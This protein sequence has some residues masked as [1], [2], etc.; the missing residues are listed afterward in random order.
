[1]ASGPLKPPVSIPMDL[2]CL[3]RALVLLLFP[4]GRSR[5]RA[6]GDTTVTRWHW[7]G[8][9]WGKAW[10]AG[11]DPALGWG[12]PARTQPPPRSLSQWIWG[13]GKGK[14][15]SPEWGRWDKEPQGFSNSALFSQLLPRSPEAREE[16]KTLSAPE[17]S[18]IG[19]IS[20]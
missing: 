13:Q 8:C 11:G 9:G 15:L 3:H 14:P 1:M 7:W 16:W 4:R 18:V 2:T 17:T 6:R 19:K 5:R 10:P 12:H 20:Q